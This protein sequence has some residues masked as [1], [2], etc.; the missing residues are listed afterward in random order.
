MNYYSVNSENGFKG[1]IIYGE[2]TYS[3][4]ELN[5]EVNRVANGLME[6]GFEKGDKVALFMR[7]SDYFM[8]TFYGVVR[9][10]CVAVPVNFR[11]TAIETDYILTQS[12][13]KC[14]FCDE[15]LASIIED[16]RGNVA[17]V[18]SV[19]SVPHSTTN[20][21]IEW[22]D[23]LSTNREQPAVYVSTISR[24]YHVIHQEKF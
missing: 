13:T 10:G 18:T 8:I 23:F 17:T 19:V 12:D 16:V 14:V 21:N 1:T 24:H 20:K 15:E 11:L 3:Y 4:Q 22:A 2:R 5:E 7:N 9:A 6:H